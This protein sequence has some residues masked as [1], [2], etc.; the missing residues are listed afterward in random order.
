[1]SEESR[2]GRMGGGGRSITLLAAALVLALALGALLWP[3]VGP[4]RGRSI[5]LV[6]DSTG[7]KVRITN[8]YEPLLHFLN[9]FTDQPLDLEVVV[10]VGAFGE[11]L[12]DGAD[13]VFCPDGL[14]LT[15][16]EGRYVPVAVGRRA[17]PRNLRFYINKWF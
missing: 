9:E 11:K 17:A 12:A 15:L 4:T 2:T 7:D 6:F 14:G 5:L 8:V 10:T 3:G 1:M 13:F 16:D